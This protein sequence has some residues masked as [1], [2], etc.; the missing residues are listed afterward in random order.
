ME[1]KG[2]PMLD[3]MSSLTFSE[4]D[5]MFE[6][7]QYEPKKQKRYART[8]MLQL[9]MTTLEIISNFQPRMFLIALIVLLR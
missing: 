2:E 5:F 4:F 8:F 3:N 1:A 7:A 6:I 9:N